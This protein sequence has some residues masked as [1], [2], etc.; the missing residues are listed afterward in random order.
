MTAKMEDWRPVAGYG[1]DYYVSDFGNVLSYKRGNPHELSKIKS[2]NGYF[3]VGLCLNGVQKMTPIHTLVLETFV[4]P[5]PEGMHACHNDGNKENNCLSNLRWDT[6]SGNMMDRVDHNTD[7]RGQKH[8][9]AKLTDE[10]VREIKS[11][12]GSASQYAIAKRFGVS[13]S[14]IYSISKGKS[15]NHVQL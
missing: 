11:L 12:L 7:L 3:A 9:L 15:W 14:A 10:S 1:G 4:S 5:R 8:P 6:R 2:S 13:R